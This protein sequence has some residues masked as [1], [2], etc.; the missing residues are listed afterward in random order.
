MQT[1]N[2]LTGTKHRHSSTLYPKTQGGVEIT[3]QE[4]DQQLRFY[5]EKIP[6]DIEQKHRSPRLCPQH[7]VALKHRHSPVET[8]KWF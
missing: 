5:L 8:R 2:K 6:T 7:R 3:M 1:V 4:I